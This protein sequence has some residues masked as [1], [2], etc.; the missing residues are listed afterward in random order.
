MAQPRIPIQDNLGASFKSQSPGG[1]DNKTQITQL[2]SRLKLREVSDDEKI[3]SLVSLISLTVNFDLSEWRRI[4]ATSG[5]VETTSNVMLETNNQRIRTLCGAVS[6]LFQ[7]RGTEVSKQP[8][9]RSLLSP[10]VS[11]LFNRDEG[12]SETGKQSLLKAFDRNPDALSGLIELGIY[13]K[14]ADNL[15]IAFPSRASNAAP[16]DVSQGVLLNVL[17]IV[18]RAIRSGAELGRK[19]SKLKKTVERIVSVNLPRQLKTLV[20][21]ILSILD[22]RRGESDDDEEQAQSIIQELQQ[23]LKEAEEKAKSA[24]EWAQMEQKLKREAQEQAWAAEKSLRDDRSV[25]SSGNM[26]G[27]MK[28]NNDRSNELESRLRQCEQD[29]DQ[30]RKRA[31]QAEQ[32]LR[33]SGGNNKQGN[34]PANDQKMRSMEMAI[35]KERNRADA[36]EQRC[37]TLEQDK[38]GNKFGNNGNISN[39]QLRNLEQEKQLEKNR[40]DIAEK[41]A[42]IFEQEQQRQTIRADVAEE[43]LQ[44]LENDQYKEHLDKEKAI[45]DLMKLQKELQL[46]NNKIMEYERQNRGPMSPPAVGSYSPTQNLQSPETNKMLNSTTSSKTSFGSQNSN[47]VSFQNPNQNQNQSINQNSQS[48]MPQIQ[49]PPPVQPTMQKSSSKILPPQKLLGT[50]MPVTGLSQQPPGKGNQLPVIA[51]FFILPKKVAGKTDKNKFVHT[52]DNEK[53]CTIAIDPVITEGVVRLEVVYEKNAGYGQSIGI[54]DASIQF[55]AHMGPWDQGNQDRTVRFWNYGKVEHITNGLKGNSD[56]KDNQRVAVEVDMRTEPRRG[57]L[58]IDNV[59]QPCYI[60]GIPDAIRFW[61]CICAPSSTFTITKFLNLNSSSAR[62][63]KGQR[64]LQWGQSW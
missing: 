11:L 30:Q 16:V 12:I 52:D 55:S 27:S 62:G 21:N 56:Y 5:V 4:V 41:N 22:E 17:E 60:T 58:F 19:A 20:N 26:S 14:A 35:Q 7:Q 23:K 38:S 57:Y 50:L 36:A 64:A 49:S 9:W 34:N 37:R 28:I 8:D 54:A 47:Q 39:L 31:D 2:A 25:V 33:N 44:K 29:R 43:R 1:K 32:Q 63:I 59:E 13:D 53:Y 51:P 40:A 48:K 6:Y 15:D 46:K 18:E 45:Q 42:Q 10:M 3:E 24:E 61:S